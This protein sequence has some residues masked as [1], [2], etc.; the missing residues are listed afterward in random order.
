MKKRLITVAILM[1]ALTGC[2]TIA[3]D[4]TQTIPLIT[5][6][7][8]VSY[9]VTDER[10]VVVS[11]GVTPS[12]ITLS[13]HNGSYFGKKSYTVTFEKE[14]YSPVSTSLQAHANGKYILGN[15]LFGGVLGWLIIDPLNGGMYDLSPEKILVE[16]DK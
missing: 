14:G 4:K 16:M 8:G 6:P 7:D 2:A 3:G 10:G 1:L 9:K 12:S 11:Q 13:K 15:L 5:N